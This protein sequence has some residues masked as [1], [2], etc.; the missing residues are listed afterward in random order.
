MSDSMIETTRWWWIRHAPIDGAVGPLYGQMDMACI[1]T[2]L[3]S[4]QALAAAVPAQAVWLTSHLRRTHET[5]S[6][7]AAAGDFT[8]APAIEPSIAEQDFGAWAGRRWNDLGVEDPEAQRAF[9]ADPTGNRPPD[10]E[11]FADVLTRVSGAIERLTAMHVG[12]DIVAVAHGGS[13]RAALA[14]ALGI[15]AAAAMALVVDTLSLTRI[16]HVAGG[17]LRGR[18]GAWRIGGVN[19][20]AKGIGN[21]LIS[22]D[23][24]ARG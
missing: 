21:G 19:L 24:I 12:R 20:P 15:D 7:I 22:T 1:T 18:G 3:S 17:L 23:A 14:M 16:D 8:V 5:A 11:S 2:D 9:W 13:I 10:G 4:F 6:A